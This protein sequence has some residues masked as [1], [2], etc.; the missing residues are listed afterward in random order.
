ME[1]G[2][3]IVGTG[4]IAQF[5]AKA[6][7]AMTGAKLVACFDMVG[8]RADAFGKENNCLAYSDLDEMLANDDV[9][10]VTICTPSGAHRDPAVAAAKAGKHLLV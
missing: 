10:V 3:G 5:H 6:L 9:H 7:E 2:F 8:E 1:I 4:M